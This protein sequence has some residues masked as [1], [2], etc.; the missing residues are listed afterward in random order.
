MFL[1][2]AISPAFLRQKFLKCKKKKKNLLQND[3]RPEHV[4]DI[5]SVYLLN[6][7]FETVSELFAKEISARI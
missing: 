5:S 6:L 3:F 4:E 7:I 2:L 1:D